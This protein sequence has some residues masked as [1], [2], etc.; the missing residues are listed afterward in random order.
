[1][2]WSL[3]MGKTEPWEILRAPTEPLLFAALTMSGL[4]PSL[5]PGPAMSFPGLGTT[6]PTS[7][8]S[9]WNMFLKPSSMSSSVISS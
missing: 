2:G 7:P 9:C 8:A 1:M 6:V 4:I 3:L 5:H